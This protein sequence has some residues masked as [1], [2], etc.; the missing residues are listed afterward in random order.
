MLV[1][2]CRH[3]STDA[4]VIDSSID[5]DEQ[6]MGDCKRP[7]QC[8]IESGTDIKMDGNDKN[9]RR[10]ER[11]VESKEPPCSQYGGGERHVAAVQVRMEK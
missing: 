1:K 3:Q 9:L 4:S 10:Q 6:G 7:G 8:L 5:D 11:E 2:A